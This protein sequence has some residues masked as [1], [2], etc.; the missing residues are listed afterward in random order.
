[1]PPSTVAMARTNTESSRLAPDGHA[2]LLPPPLNTPESQVRAL[3]VT[4]PTDVERT[5]P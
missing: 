3:S 2:A 4:A 1:M 5:L